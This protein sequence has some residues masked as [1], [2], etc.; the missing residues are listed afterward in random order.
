MTA[1]GGALKP[2]ANSRPPLLGGE[3]GG[4]L[5]AVDARTSVVLSAN[6]YTFRLMRLLLVLRSKNRMVSVLKVLGETRLSIVEEKKYHEIN[7]VS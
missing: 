5:R 7:G 3:A 1:N 4:V 2:A 6:S